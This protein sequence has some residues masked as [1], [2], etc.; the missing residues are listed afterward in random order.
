[1]TEEWPKVTARH[2]RR[3]SPWMAIIER[4][5]EFAPGA[6]CEIYD[7]VSQQDYVAI[8]AV[9]PDGR[10]PTSGNTVRRWRVRCPSCW[11]SR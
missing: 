11:V 3:V 6:K 8:V 10:V 4:Q 9:L 5:V 7:A 1:M 2:T